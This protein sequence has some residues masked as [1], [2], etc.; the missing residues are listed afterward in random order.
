M[1]IGETKSI[2]SKH[3]TLLSFNAGNRISKYIKKFVTNEGTGAERASFE[4]SVSLRYSGYFVDSNRTH[5]QIEEEN[6]INFIVG[7]GNVS[8]VFDRVVSSMKV[9]ETSLVSVKYHIARKACPNP[10]V[11]I[12]PNTD[13]IYTVTLISL[14]EVKGPWDCE[15]YEEFLEES[16]KRL[17]EGSIAFKEGKLNLASSKYNKAQIYIECFFQAYPDADPEKVEALNIIKSYCLS[18]IAAAC[19]KKERWESALIYCNNAIDS[20][21]NNLKAYYRRGLYYIEKKAWENA[22]QDFLKI[23]ERE[24]GNEQAKVALK[25]IDNGIHQ[26]LLKEKNI[27]RRVKKSLEKE[28]LYE[29]KVQEP[30]QIPARWSSYKYYILMVILIIAIIFTLFTLKSSS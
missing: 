27:Y 26:E 16:Q 22:K 2:S 21:P 12:P 25:K 29:D 19:L 7:E 4:S 8:D 1:E 13:I 18:N 5:V 30:K 6:T 24:P 9:G 20:N 14:K 23:L 10:I 3:V 28:P 15:V 11:P 17:T